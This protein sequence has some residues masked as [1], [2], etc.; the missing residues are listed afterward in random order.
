MPLL[1]G[2]TLPSE[3]FEILKRDFGPRISDAREF[4]TARAQHL[5]ACELLR[6]IGPTVM[7][8]KND[9]AIITPRVGIRIILR[10]VI[11][12]ES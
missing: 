5:D 8:L 6:F 1:A 2:V 11:T 9:F 4:V 12:V 10:R 3:I 7:G